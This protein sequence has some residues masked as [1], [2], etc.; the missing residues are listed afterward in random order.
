MRKLAYLA[1][2]SLVLSTPA[3]FARDAAAADYAVGPQYDTTH[4]YVPED[5]FDTFVASF[6]ATFGGSTASR[7]N[8]RSRPPRA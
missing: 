5:A 8:S 7:A 2:V 4:V 6:V 1:A 3:A